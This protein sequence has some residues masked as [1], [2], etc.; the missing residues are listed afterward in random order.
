MKFKFFI[1]LMGL[2]ILSNLNIVS[3]M[4]GQDQLPEFAYDFNNLHKPKDMTQLRALEAERNKADYLDDIAAFKSFSLEISA[5]I[6]GKYG[7]SS[8]PATETEQAEL[9][10]SITRTRHKFSGAK[11]ILPRFYGVDD[12]KNLPTHHQAHLAAVLTID[13]LAAEAMGNDDLLNQWSEIKAD[14]P[15]NSNFIDNVKAHAKTW[16]KEPLVNTLE[17]AIDSFLQNSKTI[18]LAHDVF[19]IF[20]PKITLKT[21]ILD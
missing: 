10:Y 3:G 6:A 2:C 12:V 11:D 17:P 18:A 19:S 20:A 5:T 9:I 4:H 1:A 21:P 13:T 7:L 15:I 8:T 16:T 14:Q